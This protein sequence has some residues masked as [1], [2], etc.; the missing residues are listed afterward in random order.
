[1]AKALGVWL[2]QAFLLSLF[3][4]SASTK[5]VMDFEQNTSQE[6]QPTNQNVL[7]QYIHSPLMTVEAIELK[8]ER[9]RLVT[10]LFATTYINHV[11]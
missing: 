3:Y 10:L 1:M 7:Q 6:N 9:S 8:Y 2:T 5:W 11:G 4:L